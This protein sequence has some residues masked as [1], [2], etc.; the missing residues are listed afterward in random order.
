VIQ[1]CASLAMG[2]DFGDFGA[3]AA[4]RQGC[5]IRDVSTMHL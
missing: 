4:R 2:L 5:K 3:T 1:A